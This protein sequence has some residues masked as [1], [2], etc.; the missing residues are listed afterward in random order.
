MLY[1]VGRSFTPNDGVKEIKAIVSTVLSKDG[2]D[3]AVR[4]MIDIIV[5][6]NNERNFFMEIWIQYEH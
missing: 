5:D 3:G 6:E 4:E 1:L 2:G